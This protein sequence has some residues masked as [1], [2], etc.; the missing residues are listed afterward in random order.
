[1][2][3]REYLMGPPLVRPAHLEDRGAVAQLLEGLE[4]CIRC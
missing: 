1:M 4:V 3:H 2:M